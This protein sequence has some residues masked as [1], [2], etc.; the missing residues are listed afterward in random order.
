M[1]LLSNLFGALGASQRSVFRGSGW[2]RGRSAYGRRAF[3][4]HRGRQSS[5]GGGLGRLILAGLGAYGLRRYFNSRNR[6]TGY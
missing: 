6:A 4:H 2:N 3:G 5:G 1:A